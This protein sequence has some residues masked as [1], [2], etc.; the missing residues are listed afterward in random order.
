[1]WEAYKASD[2]NLDLDS[3]RKLLIG[4]FPVQRFGTELLSGGK[5][6]RPL[7]ALVTRHNIVP[8]II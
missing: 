8:N 5:T 3:T 4:R 6:R 2:P 7:I 1:M